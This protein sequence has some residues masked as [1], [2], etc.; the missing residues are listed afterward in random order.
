M[1]V[2]QRPAAIYEVPVSNT[3]YLPQSM[4]IESITS[5]S[6][7]KV[8]PTVAAPSVKEGFLQRLLRSDRRRK[9]VATQETD[10]QTLAAVSS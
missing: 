3:H 5:A 8:A 9:Q 6:Q 10:G 1:L 2:G 4:S 7:S